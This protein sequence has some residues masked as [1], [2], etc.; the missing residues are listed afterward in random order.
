MKK[1]SYTATLNTSKDVKKS[2]LTVGMMMDNVQCKGDEEDILDCHNNGWGTHDCANHE[3]A[4]V[5]CI[6]G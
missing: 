6:M 4:A 1:S 5:T 2:L 3:K